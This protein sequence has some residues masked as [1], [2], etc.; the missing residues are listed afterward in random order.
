M[1]VLI[2]AKTKMTNGFCVGGIVISTR[3]LVRLLNRGNRNQPLDSEYEV[4]QIW[5]IKFIDRNPVIPPHTE[6]IIVLENSFLRNQGNLASYLKGLNLKTWEG[7]IEVIFDGQLSWSP[8]GSGYIP[9]NHILPNFSVGFWVPSQNLTFNI[10]KG[11]YSYP[12]GVSL[13][14]T[15]KYIKYKGTKSPKEVIEAGTL[16]R[17]SLAR[18]FRPESQD[19]ENGYYLQLS[20]WYE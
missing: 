2:V 16:L 7:D 14:Q 8:N 19:V 3:R 20:G 10:V 17:V 13:F 15:Y 4:G 18:I 12:S 11:K 9:E 5:N 6:D 1:E